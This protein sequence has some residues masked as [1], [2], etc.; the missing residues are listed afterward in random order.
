VA[1]VLVT[2]IA[3]PAKLAGYTA[4]MSIVY[5]FSLLLGPIIGGAISFKTTSSWRWVFLLK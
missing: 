2:E 3:P 4:N 1:S 5:A